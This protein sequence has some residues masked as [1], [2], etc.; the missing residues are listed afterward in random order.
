MDVRR[1][2]RVA[3]VAP[4]R[5]RE[6]RRD[7]V[8]EERDR[9][10]DEDPLGRAVGAAHDDQPDAD[11]GDRHR[12][13]ARGRRP[14]PSAAPT[15]TKSEMQMPR[16]ATSTASG[17]EHRPADAVLLADQL[18]QALAGDDAHARRQLLHDASETV[19]STIVHSSVVAVLGADRRSRSRCRRRRCRRW[20]RSGPGRAGRAARTGGAARAKPRRQARSASAWP[21]GRRMTARYSDRHRTDRQHAHAAHVAQPQSHSVLAEQPEAPPPAARQHRLEHVVDGDHA[22][23]PLALVDDRDDVR[24]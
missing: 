13:P 9:Q 5:V 23:H 17:G 11:R 6:D 21:T 22:D 7:R 12:R 10:P 15:P 4:V 14:A 2:D 20:R 16:F 24:L 18:G 3:D 19:I 1:D 8:G